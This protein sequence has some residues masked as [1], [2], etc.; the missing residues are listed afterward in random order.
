MNEFKDYLVRE[1]IRDING[2]KAVEFKFSYSLKTKCMKD[3]HKSTNINTIRVYI[4]FVDESLKTLLTDSITFEN[5]TL[6]KSSMNKFKNISGKELINKFN[7][8]K[9]EIIASIIN[10]HQQKVKELINIIINLQNYRGGFNN[11]IPNQYQGEC[12][13]LSEPVINEPIKKQSFEM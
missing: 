8:A 6:T 9:S 4:R 3:V 2:Y 12:I 1:Y 5:N 11:I 10:E 13:Q 7:K